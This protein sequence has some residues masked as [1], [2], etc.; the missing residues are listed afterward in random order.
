MRLLMRSEIGE[1]FN[2][3]EVH[4]S[5]VDLF[6]SPGKFYRS[7]YACP[8]CVCHQKWGSPNKECPR[9]T[10]LIVG[11]RVPRGSAMS[12]AAGI[13]SADQIDCADAPAFLVMTKEPRDK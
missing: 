4:N 13:A 5:S 10:A 7:R 9:T 3:V 1:L 6:T 11:A 8:T 2:K 12:G